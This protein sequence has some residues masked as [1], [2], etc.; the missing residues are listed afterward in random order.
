MASGDADIR[1]MPPGSTPAICLCRYF[2]YISDL[3][4]RGDKS[5]DQN[6]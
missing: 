1:E 3:E 4:N 5:L 6:F 2:V